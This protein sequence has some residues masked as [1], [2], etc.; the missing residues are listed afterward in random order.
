MG[1][2]GKI[3]AQ[4]SAVRSTDAPQ[5]RA[6]SAPAQQGETDRRL[7][8]GAD[9]CHFPLRTRW[10]CSHLITHSLRHFA[11]SAHDPCAGRA[12]ARRAEGSP[13]KP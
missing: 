10:S 8:R 2:P 12:Q 11:S 6:Q 7:G 13:L 4:G 9:P 1:L 5:A 3:T